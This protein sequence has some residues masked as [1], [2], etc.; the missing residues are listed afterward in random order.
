MRRTG[1]ES[2]TPRIVAAD[3]TAE[4]AFLR[5]AFGA[6]GEE[7]ADRPAELRIGGSLVMVSQ[8][9]PRDS[10]PAFLYRSTRRTA[11]AAP[12]CATRR[13]ACGRSRTSRA[14]RWW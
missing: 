5:A 13:A 1:F 9:G 11:I 10:F 14:H 3:A 7:H 8:A 2:I 6:T 4:V 12:W